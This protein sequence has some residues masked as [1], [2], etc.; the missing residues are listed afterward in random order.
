M[1]ANSCTANRLKHNPIHFNTDVSKLLLFLPF[2]YCT[3]SISA[4]DI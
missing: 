4:S 1:R 3:D 2:T